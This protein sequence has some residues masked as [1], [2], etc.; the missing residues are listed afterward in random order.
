MAWVRARSVEQKEQRV[1]EIVNATARLYET[2]DFDNITFA[3]IAKEAHFTR[4]NLYK[5]FN[6]KEE[7]FLELIKHDIEKWR[8]EVVDTFQNRTYSIKEFSE[9][10]IHIHMRHKRMI[11]LLTIL[12]TTLEKNSSLESLI[13]FKKKTQ[14]EFELLS[15]TLMNALPFSGPETL[16]EF[17]FAQLAMAIGTYPMLNLTHSQKQAME[18]VGMTTDPQFYGDIYARSIESLI[19]GLSKR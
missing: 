1:A 11:G 8:K 4:S 19:D 14:E 5:Y 16:Y 6:T 2:N 7:V 3:L 10:W 17:L 9:R 15:K 13:S 12:Y 18:T